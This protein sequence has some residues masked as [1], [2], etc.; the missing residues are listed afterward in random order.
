MRVQ[1]DSALPAGSTLGP[2]D[3]K[4]NHDF[5]LKVPSDPSNRARM[6][7]LANAATILPTEPL[8]DVTEIANVANAEGSLPTHA[9]MLACSLREQMFTLLQVLPK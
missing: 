5:E 2:L 4:S 6:E 8:Q 9:G 7:S 3:A 1:T